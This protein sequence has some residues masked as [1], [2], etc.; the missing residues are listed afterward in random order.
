MEFLFTFFINVKK[1]TVAVL[2]AITEI[3]RDKKFDDD[4]ETAYFELLRCAFLSLSFNGTLNRT[5][6]LNTLLFDG[7]G[8]QAPICLLY[9][10]SPVVNV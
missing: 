10:L 3:I 1:E 6:C 5:S 4:N 7:N 8:E 9:S 2:A